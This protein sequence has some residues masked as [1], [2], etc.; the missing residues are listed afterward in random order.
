MTHGT[1]ISLISIAA[2]QVIQL[3]W[4][5]TCCQLKI[6]SQELSLII[7]EIADLIQCKDKAVTRIIRTLNAKLNSVASEFIPR[8]SAPGNE[9]LIEIRY[10][11]EPI[12]VYLGRMYTMARAKMGVK[13]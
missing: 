2:R 6:V 13:Q 7:S 8:T 11:L 1:T 4:I 5:A 3:A 9:T 10:A 12:T